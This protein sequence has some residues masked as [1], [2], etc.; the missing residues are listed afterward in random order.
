MEPFNSQYFRL[1]QIY[2][3]PD[4]Q[5]H[6]DWDNDVALIK[7]KHPVVMSDK[8]TPIPLPERD[9]NLETGVGAITGWGWG[10]SFAASTHLKQLILPL[11]NH[12]AC[13]REFQGNDRTPP[14]DDNMF[15]TR[16]PD[17]YQ[18][19]C[20]GDSGSV[21]AVKDDDTGDVYAAGILSYDK[22]CSLQK[23]AV[24]MKIYSYLPWI[25]KVLR[26]D[27]EDS[28]ALRAKAMSEMLAKHL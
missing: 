19:V 4:F 2:L 12:S 28:A 1:L 6:S 3:H 16:S 5:N 9:Y 22:P 11:A 13:K 7:L 14:V 18:N 8:I 24:Y 10:I 17:S 25:Y 27:V 20:F 21:L 15:C 26:G 23:Y